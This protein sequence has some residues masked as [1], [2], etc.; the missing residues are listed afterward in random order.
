MTYLTIPSIFR[1]IG[2]QRLFT[3]G[4]GRLGWNAQFG[5]HFI[6]F[7]DPGLITIGKKTTESSFATLYPRATNHLPRDS[8]L[9]LR[10]ESV[11]G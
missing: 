10:R 3:L 1:T 7:R 6:T 8:D 9:V 11:C 4:T 2:F 5:Q